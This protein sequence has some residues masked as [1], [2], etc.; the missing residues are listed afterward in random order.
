MP[1][2]GR[3]LLLDKHQIEKLLDPDAVLAA[4]RE[5]FALHGR[6]L[7]RNFP[8][9]R[10]RLATGGIFGIK[11]G[12]VPSEGLLGLKAAGFWPR[13]RERAG[14]PHQA[15]IALF[16]PETGRPLC[17]IDGNAITTMR[18]GAAGALGLLALAPQDCTDLCIFGTGV[19]ASIQ[20]FYALRIM[21]S[22]RTI[23]YVSSDG[24]SRPG[25]E[26][27]FRE[28]CDMV[29]ARDPDAAVAASRIVVTATPGKVPLFAAGSV[30]AGTHINCVG[31]D[32]KGKRE[33]PDGLLP[34]V[35]LFVDDREQARHIGEMQWAAETPCVELSEVLTQKAQFSRSVQDVTIFDMTGLSLQ[36]LTVARMVL[37]A[38][39]ARG[40]G[41]SISWPW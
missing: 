5:A 20:L 18:T 15:T 7:G 11:S 2:D 6:G 12:D 9:V 19:Q 30:Q 16:D 26:E 8:V 35:L 32:T 36:D 25:F 24:L 21:P 37:L 34:R 14:E 41:S 17:L 23:R 38:A 22:L 4:V 13:N 31:T 40:V 39:M 28:N 3:L 10:E 1:N 27:Q 29:C 33:L